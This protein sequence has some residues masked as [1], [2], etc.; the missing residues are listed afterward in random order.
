MNEDLQKK[1]IEL[2]N[3]AVPNQIKHHNERLQMEEFQDYHIFPD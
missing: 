1:T 3:K 2:L